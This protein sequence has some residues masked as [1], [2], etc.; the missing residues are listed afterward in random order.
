MIPL[1]SS[2]FDSEKPTLL[3]YDDVNKEVMNS[4]EVSML[5]TFQSRRQ[6]ISLIIISQ[7]IYERGL[8]TLK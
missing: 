7:N 8:F 6:G 3:I 2:Y 1:D 5:M 4:A